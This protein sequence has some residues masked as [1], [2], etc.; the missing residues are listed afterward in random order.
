[1]EGYASFGEQRE[2]S[3]F[4]ASMQEAQMTSKQQL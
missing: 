1:M 2:H 3:S 4:I